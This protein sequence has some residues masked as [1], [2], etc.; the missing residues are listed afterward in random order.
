MTTVNL[1]RVRS[2][3]TFEV[4]TSGVSL[5]IRRNRS[6]NVEY[7]FEGR[8]NLV[9]GKW[10]FY[11]ISFD[12]SGNFKTVEVV[13]KDPSFASVE[14][15]TAALK[16]AKMIAAGLPD[17]VRGDAITGVVISLKQLKNLVRNVSN[18]SISK[19]F[20]EK[21]SSETPTTNIESHLISGQGP[22]YLEA[23]VTVLSFHYWG[24]R[25]R[26][27]RIISKGEL[28]K[29]EK[30]DEITVSWEEWEGS[31]KKDTRLCW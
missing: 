31:D 7:S 22:L 19:V 9:G 12:P 8:L 26:V 23:D 2:S 30:L 10:E 11:R 5:I 4:G 14:E 6:N 17:E 27:D 1:T 20:K 18:S 21:K 3:V 24:I 15:T 29:T 25:L 13:N 16:R 28:I